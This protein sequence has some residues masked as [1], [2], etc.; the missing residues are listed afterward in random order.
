MKRVDSGILEG[1]RAFDSATIFNAIVQIQGDDYDDYTGPGIR[2]MLPELGVV[3]GYAVTA[4]VTP[5]DPDPPKLSW[6]A[7]YDYLNETDGPMITVLKD[8]DARAYRAAIFGDGMAHLQKALGV[9]SAVVDGLVRD[10]TGIKAAGLPVF[11]CGLA[12][13]HGP[14]HL[15]SV[16]KP[17]TVGPLSVNNGDLLFGDMDGVVRIPLDIAGEALR[18]AG[19]IRKRER[20]FFDMVDASDFSYETYKASRKK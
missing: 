1:F 7:L 6:D 17:I 13:G 3:V 18:V 4:E 19:D 16:N 5:V 8:I 20:T 2:C 14:F 9:V 11:G 15:R 10:L 12:P